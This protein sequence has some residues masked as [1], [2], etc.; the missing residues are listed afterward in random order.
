MEEMRCSVRQA[1][2]RNDPCIALHRRCESGADD[3]HGNGL[4]CFVGR[5]ELYCSREMLVDAPRYGC[6]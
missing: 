6:E 5:N 3:V 4:V 1:D 2:Q